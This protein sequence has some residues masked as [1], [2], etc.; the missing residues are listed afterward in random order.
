MHQSY[1]RNRIGHAA[2]TLLLLLA[3]Q[4]AFASQLCAA[5]TAARASS[6]P[7]M[8]AMA[9]D[10]SAPA[11]RSGMAPCCDV[12]AS[13]HAMCVSATGDAAANV[14]AAG[15][16]SLALLSPPGDRAGIVADAPSS[17]ASS[18]TATG[19]PPLPAYI[20]FRRFLS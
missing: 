20:V 8:N 3:T 4:L 9:Q 5:V 15:S 2:L 10:A 11:V 14:L 18:L 6:I 17:S 19:G 16:A 12:D 13:H 1:T 7:T